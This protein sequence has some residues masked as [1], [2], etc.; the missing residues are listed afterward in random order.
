MLGIRQH[1]DAPWASAHDSELSHRDAIVAPQALASSLSGDTSHQPAAPNGDTFESITASGTPFADTLNGD[2]GADTLSG[3]GG[4][5][6]LNGGDGND[7][8]YGHSLGATGQI[9]AVAVA[10]GMV[11]TVAAAST[12]GDPGFIYTVSKTEGI[13]YRVNTTT[14]ARTNFLD[15]PNGEFVSDGERGVLGLAFHPDYQSNGRFF[16]FLTDPQGDLVVREYHR[17]S[18]PAVAETAFTQIIEIPKQTGFTNHNGGWIGFSPSDGYLYITTGDG[19]GGGDPSNNAQNTNVLLGKILRIDVNSD[20]FP[21]DATRYYAIPSTNPFASSAGADEIWAYGL[22]NPWRIT[23]DPRDGDIYIADVGQERREELNFRESNAAAGANFGWRLMEASLPYPQGASNPNDPAL[24]LPIYEYGRDLGGTIIGGEVYLGPNAGMTGHYFYSDFV[25]DRYFSL[26]VQNGVAVNVAE[27]TQ[28]LTGADLSFVVDFVSGTDGQLYAIGI[29]GTVWRL[30]MGPGAEDLGDTLNGGQ[31]NDTLIGGPG[32][33]T[34]RGDDGD[35]TIFW[36][37]GDDATGGNGTDMLVFTNAAAFNAYTLAGHG[38]ESAEGRFTDTGAN[39]WATRTDGY[40][41]QW[42]LE[43]TIF[44]NDNGTRDATDYDPTDA[45]I[46]DSNYS[47]EDALGRLDTSVLTYDDGARAVVDYDQANAFNW[48]TDWHSED[49]LGRVDVQVI[50]YDDGTRVVN[51]YDQ[52]NAFAWNTNWHSENALG[53]VDVSVLTNDN[54]TR[55]VNDYD[56]GDAFDWVTDWHSE[57]ALGRVDVQVVTY[58]DGTRAVNDYDQADAFDWVTNWHSEDSLGR[59]DA[60]VLTYDDG[61][62]A[63][64]DYDQA[65]DFDWATM[66]WLYD[67]NGVLLQFVGTNDDGSHF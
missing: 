19:G 9:N 62:Y 60:Q 40:D 36:D 16:V 45:Q 32:A 54:G 53:Q 47:R 25:S 63:V 43:Y 31:G 15:I 39:P 21:T 46:W 33:D 65:D 22:R 48:V 27:R 11:N 3:L 55:A 66:F 35:D 64:T 8:L 2:S 42:R 4:A 24:L 1:R 23:F 67:E 10:T 37:V 30:D 51:D 52:A 34:L 61:R 17:S 13:V 44:L 57:D 38:F 6:T 50:T 41:S 56:Q 18:N 5:D 14:G 49:T 20:A 7:V 58:D 12:A 29:G 59:V 28:Q 26:F